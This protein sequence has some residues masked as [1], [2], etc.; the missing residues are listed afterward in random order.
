MVK[1]LESEVQTREVLEWRGLHLFHAP[2]SSCSQKVRIFLA[3][4][5]VN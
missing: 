5:G 1:L 4:K 2:L 3:E